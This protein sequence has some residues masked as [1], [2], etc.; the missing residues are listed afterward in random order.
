MIPHDKQ[1]NPRST[2]TRFQ[3]KCSN[4]GIGISYI[5]SKQKLSHQKQVFQIINI[6]YIYEIETSSY[7]L[8]FLKYMYCK[9]NYSLSVKVQDVPYICDLF[10]Y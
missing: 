8:R 4:I 9:M 10:I 1:V 5:L 7:H 6:S 3:Y 2:R